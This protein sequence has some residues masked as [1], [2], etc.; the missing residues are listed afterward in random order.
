[1]KLLKRLA[2]LGYGS[3]K[4]VVQMCRDGRV[5]DAEG[6][7]LRAEDTPE[8]ARVRV[9]GAPLDPDFGMLLLLHKPIGVTC[10]HDDRGPLVHALLPPRF[11]LRRPPLSMAGRLDRATSGAL[12][13][14]DDGALLH[15]II[16]PKTRLP[17]VY[18]VTL[19]Q[20]LHGGE[21]AVFAS[22]RLYLASERD[23]LLPAHLETLAP[24]R[25]RLTLYEGRYHQVRRM[26]AAVG[27]HVLALHR[28]RI[29]AI[30]LGALEPGQWRPLAAAEIARLFA[31]A[32]A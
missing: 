3:R 19:A 31:A 14:T 5:T 7:P 18:E 24:T 28:S 1:M 23:A 2:N 10:S 21:A 22:G 32:P 11:R 29:G 20:P 12:L 9:D 27:N 8:H 16:A 26:F 17:K 4:Q 25:A 15:R 30:E 13:L 6:R